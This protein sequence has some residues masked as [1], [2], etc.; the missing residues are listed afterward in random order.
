MHVSVLSLKLGVRFFI[1]RRDED[2]I[3][4]V[5]KSLIERDVVSLFWAMGRKLV[6]LYKSGQIFDTDTMMVCAQISFIG[7]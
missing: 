3:R 5:Y 1:L 4:D 2:K 6:L 7:K